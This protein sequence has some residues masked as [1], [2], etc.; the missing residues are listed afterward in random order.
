V[1][2]EVDALGCSLILGLISAAVIGLLPAVRG[3]RNGL[4]SILRPEGRIPALQVSRVLRGVVIAEIALSFVLLIGSGLMLHSFAALQRLDPGF[5]ARDVLVF[6]VIGNRAGNADQRQALVRN[7]SSR[8]Q[9]IPGVVSVTAASPFPLADPF[10]PIRWGQED[11]LAD[12][13]KFQAAD[14]Q[15]VLPGYF[16]TLQTRLVAGRPFAST[17]NVPERGVVIIDQLLA[18]KA[19]VRAPDAV[20]RRILVR[21]RT[22]EPEWVEVI[23]VVAHQRAGSL[24]EEGREQIYFTDGFL[25]HGAVNRWAVRTSGSPVGYSGAVR[26]AIVDVSSQL[27]VEDVQSMDVLVQRSQA[28][29]RFAFMLI[30][31]LAGVAAVLAVVGV[32]GV[33]STTVRYRTAEIGARIALGAG[34]RNIFALILRHGMLL[35]SVGLAL[36]LLTAVVATRFMTTMLVGVDPVDTKTFTAIVLLYTL[37]AGAACLLPAR[38]ATKLDPRVAL[39]DQ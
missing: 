17:D 9:A 29:T 6:Q 1:A 26:A 23:G 7:I 32:Y 27:A 12:E 3:Q 4:M 35:T 34:P 24:T 39:R 15:V 16:E 5:D 31:V 11:A 22:P 18:R 20:G 30:T 21:I 10:Y 36:G 28:R 38:R 33:L 14:Y 2:F 19:F 25:G 13:S 8:L 37:V